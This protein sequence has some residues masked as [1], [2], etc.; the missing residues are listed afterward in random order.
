[1]FIDFLESV[2]SGKP[3]GLELPDIYRVNEIVLL[4]RESAEAHRIIAL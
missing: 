1:L 2:Y 3:S 4:A